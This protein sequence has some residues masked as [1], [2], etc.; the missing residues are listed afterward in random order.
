MFEATLKQV[1][2]EI[3]GAHG[4][5]VLNLDGVVVEAVDADGAGADVAEAAR[6]YTA[7]FRQLLSVSEAVETGRVL[8]FTIE[9]ATRKTFVR[10]LTP[11]Y[12]VAVITDA[13]CLTARG[14]FYLRVA[15]PDFVREL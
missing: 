9:G 3:G 10:A 11:Q 5:A 2:D 1:M 7:V 14:H 6:E 4:A 8:T 13:D 15:A 12:A